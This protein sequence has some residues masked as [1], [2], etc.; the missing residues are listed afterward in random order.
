MNVFKFKLSRWRRFLV[1]LFPRQYPVEEWYDDVI[2]YALEDSN[3]KDNT[4]LVRLY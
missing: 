4:V 3:L 2:G 1:W